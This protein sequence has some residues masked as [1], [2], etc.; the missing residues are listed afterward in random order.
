MYVSWAKIRETHI[1]VMGATGCGKGVWLAMVAYQC[2]LAGEGLIFLDPKNDSYSPDLMRQAALEAGKKFHLINLAIGQPP[3]VNL[4]HGA[5]KTDIA[6]MK[7]SGFDLVG[8][9]TDADFYRGKDQDAAYEAADVAAGLSDLSVPNLYAACMSIESITDQENFCRKLQKL[10]NVTAFSTSTGIN[11]T[12]AI[13]DGDVIYIIGSATNEMVKM[14]QRMLLIRLIQ[15]ILQ[16]DR[17]KATIPTAVVLDEVKHIIT[18]TSLTALGVIRDFNAHFFLAHQSIGD[19]NACQGV[20]PQEV[21][22]AV[23]DNTTIKIIYKISDPVFAQ[24]LSLLGGSIK[25]YVESVSKDLNQNKRPDGTWREAQAPLISADQITHLPMPS[26]RPN[27]ASVGYL[28]GVKTAKLFFVGPVKVKTKL[29][30]SSLQESLLPQNKSLTDTT[31]SPPTVVDVKE[32][33]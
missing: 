10:S 11:L 2:I 7:I 29:A 16:R 13:E 33:I 28:F 24:K 6:E 8:M 25:T 14:A 15:I 31:E 12:K 1:Q 26:D 32:L 23:V 5:S 19:L 4:Y 21:Y 17:S 27:Q 9:G 20:T 22:G 3:Q 30:V 18:K